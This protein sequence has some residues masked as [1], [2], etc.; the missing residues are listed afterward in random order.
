[1]GLLTD[2]RDW[3]HERRRDDIFPVSASDADSD[4]DADWNYEGFNEA[5]RAADW[6]LS[7]LPGMVPPEEE[8][9]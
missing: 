3:M 5:R 7:N 8:A 6:I 4:S 2:F 1:M 9:S